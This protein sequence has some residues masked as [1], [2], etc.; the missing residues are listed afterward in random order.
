MTADSHRSVAQSPGTIPA[1][2][3]RCRLSRVGRGSGAGCACCPPSGSPGS[4]RSPPAAPR[5]RGSPPARGSAMGPLLAEE[6]ASVCNRVRGY[7]PLSPPLL[8][9]IQK[10]SLIGL[11]VSAGFPVFI[12]QLLGRGECREVDVLHAA[13]GLEEVGQVVLLREPGELR[14]VVEPHVDNSPGTGSLEQRKKPAGG[15]LSE[16][17][18]EQ[19][20]DASPALSAASV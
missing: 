8:H 6:E 16:P 18:G 20:H 1:A 2:A 5:G 11:P 9:Q 10:S 7:S 4:G 13:D 14:H 12:E 3:R 15:L 17:D 19:R